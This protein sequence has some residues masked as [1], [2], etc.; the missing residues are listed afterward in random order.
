MSKKNI[1]KNLIGLEGE[2][3]WK[4]QTSKTAES[5]KWINHVLTA[6]VDAPN[7]ENEKKNYY[8]LIFFGF[9][10]LTF[11]LISGKL[12]D[13]QIVK[14]K[15]N[16]NSAE[17]NR[18]KERIVRA[19]RGIIYDKNGTPLVKNVPNYDLVITPS[20]LPAEQK[21]R[22]L[23]ISNLAK[24]TNSSVEDINKKIIEKGSQY[25]QPVLISKNLTKDTAIIISSQIKELKGISIEVNPIREYLDGGLL[26]HALGYVGRISE[27]E[28]KGNKNYLLTDFIGKSGIEKTYENQ[29]KGINGKERIEVNSE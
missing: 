10:I 20:N 7:I 8:F 25:T 29:L 22:D 4:I 11:I 1:F 16:F 27:E 24:I 6:D 28:L 23:V 5:E 3:K 2:K 12:F 13:L 26:S 19:P 14:G 18:L 9:I 21:E 15:A 17:L